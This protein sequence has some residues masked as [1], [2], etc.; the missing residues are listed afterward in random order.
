M[1]P[2]VKPGGEEQAQAVVEWLMLFAFLIAPAIIF[3]FE[4][5]DAM[6]RFYSVSSWAVSLPFP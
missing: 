6:C 5:L 3:M 2:G 4:I 1:S